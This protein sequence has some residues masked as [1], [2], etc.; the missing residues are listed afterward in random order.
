M[1]PRP[2]PSLSAPVALSG[3]HDLGRFDCDKPAL[4]DWLRNRALTSEG[5]SARCLVVCDNDVVVGYYCIATGSVAR[6]TEAP[7]KL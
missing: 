7:K 4:N 6:D 1:T 2:A 5:K 3:K